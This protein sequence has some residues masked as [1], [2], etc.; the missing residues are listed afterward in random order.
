MKWTTFWGNAQSSVVPQPQ[1]YAKDLTLRYPIF[2][3]FDGTKIRIT[4]DNFCVEEYVTIDSVLVSIGNELSD[5][6]SNE[7]KYL[8]FNKNKSVT[9]DKNSYVISDE[10]DINLKSNEYLIVSI[11]LKDY[12]NL[13]GGV[14][15]KG[16]LSKGYFAYGN[17][18][19]NNK[20]D[21]NTSKSTSWVYFLSNID[22]YTDDN[23]MALICYGDS[24]T[25]Q[26]WSDYMLLHLREN[27][28]NNIAVIRK[29]VSGTRILRQYEC[30]TYK[31]YGLNGKNR[32]MHEI[33]SVSNA[34]YVIIQHGIND[35]IHPVGED[36]NIFRPM[37]DLPTANELFEGIN[38]YKECLDKLNLKMIVGTLLPI[39]NWRT[40]MPF[41]ETLKND[42]NKLLMDNYECIDFQSEIGFLKDDIWY[43]KDGCDSGDHLHPSK[44][45]YNKMG[46]LAAK[47]IINKLK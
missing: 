15:I 12:T 7:F 26:D 8:T 42:F 45:A 47:Y 19:E 44:D 30:I 36:I 33:S 38:Y 22:I 5:K 16:P 31:S 1:R 23:N 4:L 20:L 35:I 39:Y 18:I 29:A 21:I 41:R 10:L 46:N 14:D 34:K 2:I 28:V 17:Q 32:F 25:S 40:Y 6:Q 24:I 43:F 13:T 9:I 3:P 11:Y 37:S 27:N